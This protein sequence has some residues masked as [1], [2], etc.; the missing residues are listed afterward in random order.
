MPR[1]QATGR[2]LTTGRLRNNTMVH[3]RL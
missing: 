2:G 1:D 3:M